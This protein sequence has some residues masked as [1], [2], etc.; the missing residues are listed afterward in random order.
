MLKG[1]KLGLARL[2]LHRVTNGNSQYSVPT[3][4]KV[5]LDSSWRQY[6]GQR[7]EQAVNWVLQQEGPQVMTFMDIACFG[8]GDPAFAYDSSL[9]LRV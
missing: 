7:G 6:S 3:H 2:T 5:R 9:P 8:Q 4:S 1:R